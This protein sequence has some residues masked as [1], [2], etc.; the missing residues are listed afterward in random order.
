MLLPADWL[1]L[2]ANIGCD[3]LLPERPIVRPA[4]P[5]AHRVPDI[6][7]PERVGEVAVG[8]R[9]A[10]LA[11]NRHND[12]KAANLV[13]QLPILETAHDIERIVVVNLLVVI[14]FEEAM[15]IVVARKGQ[16]AP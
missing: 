11:P 6:L 14:A 15:N 9:G 4:I 2:S 8:L 13:Q 7:A 10:I 12:L 3:H 5:P 16:H 1:L